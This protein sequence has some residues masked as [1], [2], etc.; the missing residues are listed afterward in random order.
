AGTGNAA[1][2]AAI[3]QRRNRLR[4]RSGLASNGCSMVTL[5]SAAGRRSRQRCATL[6]PTRPARR[7]LH[8][9]GMWLT[10]DEPPAISPTIA[11]AMPT[12]SLDHRI[13]LQNLTDRFA[14]VKLVVRK[15]QTGAT[16]AP[17]KVR[18]KSGGPRQRST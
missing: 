4:F 5:L 7:G 14:D 2:A 11:K 15:K 17:V 9:E 8:H 6:T 10:S 1:A 13:D 16:G 18:R 3:P 12:L